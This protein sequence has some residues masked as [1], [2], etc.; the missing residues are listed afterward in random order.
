MRHIKLLLLIGGHHRID[1][2][3][4]RSVVLLLLLLIVVVQTGAGSEFRRH[5]DGGRASDIP[6]VGLPQV[7]KV[8]VHLVGREVFVV[9]AAAAGQLLLSVLLA[10]KLQ[11]GLSPMPVPVVRRRRRLAQL[12]TRMIAGWRIIAAANILHMALFGR[13]VLRV[14]LVWVWVWQRRRRPSI[15]VLRNWCSLFG[16]RKGAWYLRQVS[17]LLLLLKLLLFVPVEF[18]LLLKAHLLVHQMGQKLVVCDCRGRGVDGTALLG[19]AHDVA[20]A[21]R[22]CVLVGAARGGRVTRI[23]TD[24]LVL[25]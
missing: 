4:Q 3:G 10:L 17:A 12:G 5:A 21:A 9:D 7:L 1:L 15:G 11:A 25:R 2:V 19:W 16:R 13:R 8:F 24:Q 23:D 14:L 22:V 18:S 20:A 6:R